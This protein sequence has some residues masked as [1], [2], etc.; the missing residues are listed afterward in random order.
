MSDQFLKWKLIRLPVLGRVLLFLFRILIVLNHL[1]T[2]LFGTI[3]WLFKSNEATNFTYSL[4]S[5]NRR[6][7]AA[8]LS[9]VTGAQIAEAMKYFEEIENDEQLRRHIV[10]TTSKSDWAILADPIP[11]YARRIGWYA[12]VRILKPRVVVETGV[13]KGLGSCVLAAAV[14]RNAEEGH[15]GIYYG[16]D[17]NPEAGYLFTAPYNEYGK[18]LVDDSIKS[19]KKLAG[20][21]DLFI[22]DSDHS[23][24]YEY[25]EYLTIEDKLSDKA[26]IFGDNSHCTDRLIQFAEKT[27]RRFLFFK[28]ETRRHWY[29][30][31]GIGAAFTIP[32]EK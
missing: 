6:Y 11:Q 5:L 32:G 3:S 25:D 29:E 7:L 8:F 2:N 15:E 23:A 21:I 14:K 4:T 10:E 27:G 18:I 19:L 22:N 28:E 13:D 1:K 12:A 17:I 24:D 26:V 9:Q 31:A 20:P 30:G 16:T